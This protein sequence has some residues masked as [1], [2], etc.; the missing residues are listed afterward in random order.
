MSEMEREDLEDAES[1]CR[2]FLK[3]NL[4]GDGGGNVKGRL[5]EVLG[6]MDNDVSEE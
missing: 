1:V 5:A 6:R 3:W 2:K 4:E